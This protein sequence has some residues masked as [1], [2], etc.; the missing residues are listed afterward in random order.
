MPIKKKLIPIKIVSLGDTAHIRK[1]GNPIVTHGTFETEE[2]VSLMGYSQEPDPQPYILLGKEA[3]YDLT[4]T[5]IESAHDD[6]AAWLTDPKSNKRKI[7]EL[8][9]QWKSL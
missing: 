7:A 3:L 9:K 6:L 8:I 5:I 4:L 1:S 2:G